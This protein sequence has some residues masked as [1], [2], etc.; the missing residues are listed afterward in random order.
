M[1]RHILLWVALLPVG[2]GV[3]TAREPEDAASTESYSQSSQEKERLRDLASL[4]LE[5]AQLLEKALVQWK[6]EN[7]SAGELEFEWSQI[8]KY[9]EPG[10]SVARFKGVDLE[11][12][13]YQ[14]DAEKAKVKIHPRTIKK[15]YEVVDATFWGDFYP[16]RLIE[17]ATPVSEEAELESARPATKDEGE[18]SATASRPETWK[19]IEA[20]I[21]A[22][23]ELEKVILHVFTNEAKAT[24]NT[25]KL[26]ERLAKD[27]PELPVEIETQSEVD[28]DTITLLLDAVTTAGLKRPAIK[29]NTAPPDREEQN[30]PLVIELVRKEKQPETGAAGKAG[31][32]ATVDPSA[33]EITSDTPLT[34]KIEAD[35]RIFAQEKEYTLE[36]LSS[37]LGSLFESDKS[38][39]RTA[40]E[41]PVIISIHSNAQAKQATEVLD[42][43]GQAGF[44]KVT[45]SAVTE[46]RTVTAT[47]SAERKE[48]EAQVAD[49]GAIKE[50]ERAADEFMPEGL[51]AEKTHSAEEFA[52]KA[53]SKETEERSERADV[54]PKEEATD[55]SKVLRA[56]D[57]IEQLR[58]AVSSFRALA[59]RNP[60][61]EEGLRALVEKPETFRFGN[62]RQLISELPTDPWD[63]AYIYKL[64]GTRSDQDPFDLFSAGPDGKPGNEDDIGNWD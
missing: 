58:V 44:R 12:N 45:V 8:E 52:T 53:D 10:S 37:F 40:E 61:T 18:G 46:E 28:S 25:V 31:T 27:S 55:V 59:E 11:N 29:T 62:W 24:E 43:L 34:I 54:E 60:T 56:V 16:A 41:R 39:G 57:D 9:L 5:D 47:G 38:R 26:F 30:K 23:N 17:E 49:A 51:E 13:P 7:K 3:S 63:N 4:I 64:P 21:P 48:D 2:I 35:G 50:A 6:A 33:E 22:G 1:I 32:T 15:Y 42:V 19:E 20:Q 36:Q 14:I